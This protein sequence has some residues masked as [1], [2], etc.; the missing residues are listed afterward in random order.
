MLLPGNRKKCAVSRSAD[1]SAYALA[2]RCPVPAYEAVLSAYATATECP[3]ELEE[4]LKA[5]EDEAGRMR[6]EQA[7]REMAVMGRWKE[8]SVC[9]WG[10]S[11][12]RTRSAEL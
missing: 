2:T 9:S 1:L 5:Q 7:L 10:S 3:A 6:S 12:V 8:Q 4:K 11:G